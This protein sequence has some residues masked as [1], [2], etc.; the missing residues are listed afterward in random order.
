MNVVLENYVG[1]IPLLHRQPTIDRGVVLEPVL[2]GRLG[3][4]QYSESSSCL[5][6]TGLEGECLCYIGHPQLLVDFN[7]LLS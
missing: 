7:V 5:W 2:S 6:K 1:G 4:M 3:S